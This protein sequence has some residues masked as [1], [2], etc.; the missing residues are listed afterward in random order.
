MV[1]KAFAFICVNSLDESV[2]FS[3]QSEEFL[4][5]RKFQSAESVGKR[6]STLETS[7]AKRIT[8]HSL[9]RRGD[10]IRTN[11]PDY[12]RFRFLQFISVYSIQINHIVEGY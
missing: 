4:F 8:C 5:H 7:I 3:E 1:E 6:T 10:A 12:I 11:V 9:W 2:E